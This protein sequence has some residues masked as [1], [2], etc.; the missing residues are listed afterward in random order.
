M[1]A[2]ARIHTALLT[3]GLALAM[4]CTSDEPNSPTAPPANPV[5]P[6]PASTLNVT[7]NA[8]RSQMVVGSEAFATIVVEARRSDNGQPP[9]DLTPV[10]LT[11]TLGGFGSL[12]GPQ[13][14]QGEL[15]NGRF[16]TVFFPGGTVGTATIRAQVGTGVGFSSIRINPEETATFFISSVTPNVGG[17]LG[18]DSV[19]IAGGGFDGPLRVLFG[20]IP[21]TIQSSSGSQIR[22]LTPALVTSLAQ[23]G[24]NPATC[25]QTVGVSVTINLNE[26]GTATDTLNNAFSYSNGG[27]QLLQPII[28]SVTPS[29]GPNEGGTQVAI[30]GD[31]FDAP[32]KVEFGNTTTFVEA[33]LVSVERTRIV[34]LTP[35]A[36]AFGQGNLNQLVSI[37]VT[38]LNSGR[39][40][41]AANAFRYG[42]SMLITAMGPT[43]GTVGGGTQVTIFGQGFDEPV[44]VQFGTCGGQQVLS[45]SGTEIVVLTV[46]ETATACADVVCGATLVTNIETGN[47]AT[48]P[49]FTFTVA[50]PL[51]TGISPSSGSVNSNTTISGQNFAS[52]VQVL[53]GG[54][55]GSAAVI[56]S[57]SST[58]ISVKVPP[59]PPGFVFNTEP[60]DS[61]GDLTLDGTRPVPTP[62]SVTVLNLDG[63]TCS[64]TLNNAFTLTPPNSSCVAGS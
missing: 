42:V 3:L 64:A 30:N 40:A 19:T 44:A 57:K 43:S 47:S 32:V 20:G 6:V 46:A 34:V 35:A 51:I 53:F 52:N 17:P 1:R 55:T 11:T 56:N 26:E 38:N 63:S 28:F 41:T 45:V 22:V 9:P 15:V 24:T 33:Q 31:G 59:P 50:K 16:Q 29:I 18:G 13:T 25:N 37:R 12:G 23:C 54:P 7:V 39:Q 4:G 14:I 27:G 61:D 8:S 5:P 60:C 48:G 58:S 62:I 21:A 2:T 10:T 49:V 36:T